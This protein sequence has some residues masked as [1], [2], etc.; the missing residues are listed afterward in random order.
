[1]PD[2]SNSQLAADIQNV[3]LGHQ[4]FVDEMITWSTSVQAT[5]TFTDPY[6][7]ESA[8]IKTPYQMQLDFENTV[9]S[10]SSELAAATLLLNDAN[11]L[12]ANAVTYDATFITYLGTT[13]GYRDNAAASASAASTS[14]TNAATSATNASTSETN[15]ATSASNAA[16]SETNAAASASAAS[17]S[18]TNAGISETNAAASASNAATSETNAG[19]SE[20]NASTSETNSGISETNAAA[21]ETA[22]ATSATNASTSETNAASSASAAST[23][24]SNA[25][26]SETNAATSE[27][28]AASSASSASAS[29]AAAIATLMESLGSSPIVNW[30]GVVNGTLATPS[31]IVHTNT[32]DANELVRINYSW[33]GNDLVYLEIEVSTNGGSTYASVGECNITY[34]SGLVSSWSWS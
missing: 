31:S 10:A 6:T 1:M 25:S 22:A 29:A 18:E 26:T 30:D 23:S 17:T 20:T 8:A 34:S 28:N 33:S 12:Y 7:L 24:A 2:I 14:E 4:T 9:G 16:T 32:L 3:I 27:T 15:A 21:S 19:I 13:L 5:E 11:T